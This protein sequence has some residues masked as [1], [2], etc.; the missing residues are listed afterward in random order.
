MLAFKVEKETKRIVSYGIIWD[1]ASPL[2]LSKDCFTELGTAPFCL[3]ESEKA[4]C[5]LKIADRLVDK[6]NAIGAIK[7]I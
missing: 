1:R 2:N 7:G 3:Y 6:I 4:L 5:D